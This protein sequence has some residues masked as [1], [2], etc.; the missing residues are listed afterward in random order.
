MNKIKCADPISSLERKTKNRISKNLE[1]N[2]KPVLNLLLKLKITPNNISYF[3]ALIGLVATFFLW[4][5]QNIAGILFALSLILDNF[6]G[7]LARYSD[8]ASTKGAVTDC[9]ADQITISASTIGL[10]LTGVMNLKLGLIYLVFYPIL[11]IF[12]I[13]RNIIN[14]PSNFVL[15]P[16][17]VV[18]SFFWIYLITSLNLINLAL[19]PILIVMGFH[20]VRDFIHLRSKL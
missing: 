14:S 19:L 2:T 1:N 12:S 15:R 20:I 4:T 3:S 10:I 18:Y 17:I 7:I 13:L 11:I 8:Q 6:D 5:N 16:R 9:F